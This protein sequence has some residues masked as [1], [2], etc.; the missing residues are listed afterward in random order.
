MHARARSCFARTY[1]HRC[2][3]LDP[4][5][6]RTQPVLRRSIATFKVLLVLVVGSA[7]Q[8]GGEIITEGLMNNN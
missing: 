4:R 8:D 1:Q 6:T 2:A 5:P 7:L 3:L